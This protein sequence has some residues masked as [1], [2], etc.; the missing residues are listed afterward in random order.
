MNKLANSFS[1]VNGLDRCFRSFLEDREDVNKFQLLDLRINEI[2]IGGFQSIKEL[3]NEFQRTSDPRPFLEGIAHYRQDLEVALEIEK[4]S[5]LEFEEINSSELKLILESLVKDLLRGAYGTSFQTAFLESDPRVISLDAF[6]KLT[7][8]QIFKEFDLLSEDARKDLNT[9]M[10]EARS[11]FLSTEELEHI[12]DLRFQD[13][14]FSLKERN[15]NDTLLKMLKRFGQ[16][17]EKVPCFWVLACLSATVQVEEILKYIQRNRPSEED[18]L[19]TLKTLS[20]LAQ[21]LEKIDPRASFHCLTVFA[22]LV[23]EELA[24]IALLEQEFVKRKACWDL[25]WTL[26]NCTEVPSLLG[27]NLLCAVSQIQDLFLRGRL[28]SMLLEIFQKSNP[29]VV[30]K[31]VLFFYKMSEDIYSQIEQIRDKERRIK[32]KSL[33]FHCKLLVTRS[34]TDPISLQQRLTDL[35][36]EAEEAQCLQVALKAARFCDEP[37]RFSRLLSWVLFPKRSVF[38]EEVINQF[39]KVQICD[40][41]VDRIFEEQ[42]SGDLDLLLLTLDLL[43]LVEDEQEKKRIST[44]IIDNVFLNSEE[45]SKEDV[46]SLVKLVD[47]YNRCFFCET[48]P[49]ERFIK[50]S[51]LSLSLGEWDVISALNLLKRSVERVRFSENKAGIDSTLEDIALRLCFSSKINEELCIGFIRILKKSECVSVLEKVGDALKENWS[52]LNRRQKKTALKVGKLISNQSLFLTLIKGVIDQETQANSVAEFILSIDNLKFQDDLIDLL[53]GDSVSCEFLDKAFEVL[54]DLETGIS[55]DRSYKKF[56]ELV[57]SSQPE[58]LIL[59]CSDRLFDLV[60]FIK[61]DTVIQECLAE[62]EKRFVKII[63]AELMRIKE[64]SIEPEKEIEEQERMKAI[65]NLECHMSLIGNNCIREKLISSV[66]SMIF[67][68]KLSLIQNPAARSLGLLDLILIYPWSNGNIVIW[69]EEYFLKEVALI[70]DPKKR[71]EVLCD[72]ISR[73]LHNNMGFVFSEL[74]FKVASRIEDLSVQEQAQKAIQE[75]VERKDQYKPLEG[76]SLD[77]VLIRQEWW[78]KILENNR[79]CC[80]TV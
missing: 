30:K 79:S 71:M 24:D 76:C 72:F 32:E 55:K 33:F 51:N 26:K 14:P 3:W 73:M 50:E 1:V 34:A 58:D 15:F 25:I 65:V 74:L 16:F 18:L 49:L 9:F 63:L 67:R 36:Q 61:D 19:K 29:E 43:D 37:D 21:L 66:D 62:I 47:Y 27:N 78:Q 12:F 35:S 6:W 41:V 17:N 10:E 20:C 31:A 48:D 38:L 59:E 40:D 70:E 11:N 2:A 69:S 8:I 60:V 44:C 23:K 52:D 5:S 39:Q 22:G 28:L 75:A 77:R 54:S 68:R 45:M 64:I 80:E 46:K 7:Y 42:G 13:V 57:L 53:G 4:F 56:I